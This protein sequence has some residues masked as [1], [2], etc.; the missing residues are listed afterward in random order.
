MNGWQQARILTAAQFRGQSLII[1]AITT[2]RGPAVLLNLIVSPAAQ[3][4][5]R[6]ERWRY[7]SRSSYPPVPAVWPRT[8]ADPWKMASYA[9][10]VLGPSPA[11]A[12]TC[13][14]SCGVVQP[15]PMEEAIAARLARIAGAI[16]TGSP[17]AG[18]D[19]VALI[20]DHASKSTRSQNGWVELLEFI[21]DDFSGLA[22]AQFIRGEPAVITPGLSL[23]WAQEIHQSVSVTGRVAP[24]QRHHAE[25]LLR[26]A[27]LQFGYWGAFKALIKTVPV[28]YLPEAYAD[29]L[30]RLASRDWSRPAPP[31]VH[32]DDVSFLADFS[33][34]ASGRTIAYLGRR[35]RRD[36]AALAK[37]AP[38]T[39]AQVATRLMLSWDGNLTR[40]SFAP[41][42]IM[43]GARS[44][45]DRHSSYVVTNPV[46][47]SRRDAHPEIWNEHP[48]LIQ[49]IFDGVK[50]SVEAH[51]WA[52]QVLES[53]GTPPVITAEHAK[54]AV[55]STYPPLSRAACDAILRRPGLWDGLGVEHWTALFVNGDD[56][57]V[58]GILDTMTIGKVRPAALQAAR[59]FLISDY[60]RSSHRQLS[61]A[62]T[63]L[64][65]SQPV[66]AEMLD[67]DPAPFVAAVLAVSSDAALKNKKLWLPVVKELRIE[68]LKRIREALPESVRD[69]KV[70]EPLGDQMLR[71]KAE[72]TDP[73]E[74]IMWI[75]SDNAL[76]SKLGWQLL[77][78]GYGVAGLLERLPRWLGRRKPRSA[79]VARILSEL[80]PRTSE[81]DARQIGLIAAKALQSGM[82][83]DELAALLLTKAS[84]RAALWH[85][86]GTKPRGEVAAL[87]DGTSAARARM[88]NSIESDQL[89]TA[90]RGQL[91]FIGRYISGSPQRIEEEPSFGVAA[92]TSSSSALRGEALR[93]LGES[94]A[95]PEVWAVLA[96]SGVPQAVAAARNYLVSL[97]DVDA[98]RDAVQACLASTLPHMRELGEQVLCGRLRQSGDLTL[99]VALGKSDTPRILELVA[100]RAVDLEPAEGD[101]LSGFDH[102]VMAASGGSRR[103]K[104]AVKERLDG[105]TAE[106]GLA[107]PERINT[108]L[109]IARG[110][111]L[112]DREW[113]L[114]KLAELALAG[115]E[116]DGLEV[117]L[118]TTGDAS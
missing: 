104:E 13:C 35:T 63:F 20:E 118:V 25:L 45:L 17:S 88:G 114:R 80:L 97:T 70:L 78:S 82:D 36:L 67:A 49:R 26:Y 32:I 50:A 52:Y 10:P 98:F 66:N 44:P 85:A 96:E 110:N 8:S 117:S 14:A 100:Q 46:M 76:E 77:A 102:R 56:S 106:N 54:L 95:F 101:R 33:A 31:S 60:Q 18:A 92:A 113:A 107:S 65:A 109:E 11:N 30:A 103:A 75:A 91:S 81:H 55:Q 22:T 23:A 79:V 6:V 73:A 105:L 19:V 90:T 94:G 47:T 5:L 40:T 41:A 42:Y 111:T 61:V 57:A 93:Q 116:I 68:D 99:L 84:G 74:A 112:R 28:D 48:E 51:T 39:Y 1:R 29:G 7:G 21:R 27:P 58:D 69:S 115:V 72:Q 16:A 37:R 12:V 24:E 108:L 71:R 38:D 89:A 2:R 3:D 9:G 53:C 87:A 43:L 62:L 15:D 64:S 86:L 4:D 83:S 34:A 59:G